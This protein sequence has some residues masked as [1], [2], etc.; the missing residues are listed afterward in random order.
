MIE[1]VFISSSRTKFAHIEYFLEGSKY[2]IAPQKN[3]GIGYNEPRIYDRNQLLKESY[4]DAKKR[5]EKSVGNAENKF[6]ILEDTSVIIDALSDEKN[7]IP[8][9]DIKYWM[10]EHTF[11]DIDK[12]LK[13]HNNNRKCIVRSD[14]LLHLPYKLQ[15]K[16][17]QE[18]IIFTG[19]EEG[20]ICKQEKYFDIN[21]LYPWLDNKTFNKWFVPI[22]YEK[23]D[24]S[25]SQ[26][27]IENATRYDFRC[28][29]INQMIDFLNKEDLTE[30]NKDRKVSYIP[31]LFDASTFLLLGSTCA[32][33]STLADYMAKK[34]KY[35]HIE[36]S[37][38]MYL[39][40]YRRHGVNPNV[41]IGDFAQKAL[42]D[43]P[44]IV[45]KQVVEFCNKLGSIPIVISGFRT[46]KEVKYFQNHHLKNIKSVYIDTERDIRYERCKKRNRSD[47]ALTIDKFKKKDAQQYA[48]GVTVL[49]KEI[50]DKLYNNGTFEEYYEIFEM[51]FN[52][53]VKSYPNEKIKS[54]YE[55][56]LEDFILIALSDNVGKFYTTTEIAKLINKK[57]SYMKPKSKNNVSRYFNQFFHPYYDILIDKDI[58]KY[59]INTTGLSQSRHLFKK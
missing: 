23:Q 24:I 46:L 25:I 17:N 50:K 16:Y 8:G 49:E 3:Y 59:A 29:A 22:D 37:D 40:Y 28:Q 48:M 47:A 5:F 52:D 44:T 18:Y 7:E 11:D 33:K 45:A 57:F 32:G 39:E 4:V 41:S 1:I 56:R 20:F 53:L 21:P 26:L 27:E 58:N 9:L 13:V 2:Y 14:I 10:K 54:I 12:L 55:M 6:F 51:S 34:Y 38:F 36:A 15:K 42:E 43:N 31:T 30:F 35:Y 19:M